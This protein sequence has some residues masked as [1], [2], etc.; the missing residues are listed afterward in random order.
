MPASL[1]NSIG[2]L[3]RKINIETATFAAD[4]SGQLIPTW[5]VKHRGVSAEVL[6]VG[7]GEYVRGQQV[8]A[9]INTLVRIRAQLNPNATHRI[10]IG[11]RTLNVDRV[12]DL[13]GRQWE[14]WLHCKEIDDG[15]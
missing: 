12:I 7:G 1:K 9:G 6:G 3:N 15:S 13:T 4:S 11:D 14:L 5:S 10:V 8:E 2:R